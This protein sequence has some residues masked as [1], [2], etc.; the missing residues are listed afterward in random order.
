MSLRDTKI[1]RQEKSEEMKGFGPRFD[2]EE[3]LLTRPNNCIK[4]ES[5]HVAEVKDLSPPRVLH[6]R[7]LSAGLWRSERVCVVL[8]Y[9]FIV[10]SSR[11]FGWGSPTCGFTSQLSQVD[12]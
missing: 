3:G 8:R 1:Y 5:L 11:L 9:L 6:R 7:R 12:W 10:T 4:E 2:M